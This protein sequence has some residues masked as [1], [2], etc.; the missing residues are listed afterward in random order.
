MKKV[1]FALILLGL[2]TFGCSSNNEVEV[3][4]RTTMKIDV[5]YNA[6]KV[7]VGEVINAKFNVENTG[8]SPLILS[9]VKGTCGCTVTDWSKDPIAPGKIG[10][11]KAQ[12][13]TSGFDFGPI[14]KSITVA[15]NT[16]PAVTQVVV[17]ANIIK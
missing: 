13:N 14:T 17:K 3:G 1:G 9:E 10:V 4:F 6:G 2:V 15:S 12:V 16:T 7:A 8:D 11:V 5:V